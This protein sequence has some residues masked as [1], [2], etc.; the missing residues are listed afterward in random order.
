MYS[1]IDFIEGKVG[2]ESN[3]LHI[4]VDSNGP[5]SGPAA[6]YSADSGLY[7]K[8]FTFNGDAPSQNL[9]VYD[10]GKTE[11]ED[12][13]FIVKEMVIPVYEE[14]SARMGMISGLVHKQANKQFKASVFT[15]LKNG[16][17]FKFSEANTNQ[18]CHPV[19]DSGTSSSWYQGVDLT[20]ELSFVANGHDSITVSDHG[21][22]LE[23]TMQGTI[24]T[25]VDIKL[26]DGNDV[27]IVVPVASQK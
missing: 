27:N 22:Y 2:V 17:V 5:L 4:T 9:K 25:N 1:K 21:D 20:D 8:K 11:S 15:E 16:V 12:A 7:F 6:S 23:L 14:N 10:G 26:M 19:G 13:A 18:F 24:T 3:T